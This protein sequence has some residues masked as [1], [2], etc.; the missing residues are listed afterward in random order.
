LAAPAI[1]TPD[2]RLRVFVSSTIEELAAEREA[3]REAIERLRLT[4]VLF[5]LGARSLPP[6]DVYRAYLDDSD[7]FVG[8]YGERYGWVGPGMERSGLEDE[9]RRSTSKPRLIYVKKSAA[10]RDVRLTALIEEIENDAAIS[11]KTFESAESL[12]ELL[13]DDLAVLLT[14]RFAG[15]R[16]GVRFRPTLPAPVD[17]FVGRVEELSRIDE[18]L[19]DDTR[20][21]TIAGPG[22]VGKS[23]LALE[24]ARRSEARFR[25]GAA[26]VPL[27]AVAEP[28]LVASTV[29]ATL[30]LRAD[31]AAD[32]ADALAEQLRDRD[33]LLV[34]DNFE[35]V[36][37][38]APTVG[39]LLARCP[40]LAVLAT[41]RSPLRIRGEHEL[42]IEPLGVP[43]PASEPAQVADADAVRLFADRARQLEPVFEL[44]S[45]NSD[46]IGELCRKLEGLPLALELAAARIRL[47]PPQAMLERVEAGLDVLAEGARDVPERQ[48]SLRATIEWSF[49]L[50]DERERAA[51]MEASVFRGGWDLGAAESVL[52][53]D[54]VERLD[55]LLEHSLIKRLPREQARFGMLESIRALAAERL[56]ATGRAANV[57]RGHAAFYLA[58]VA[59]LTPALYGLGQTAALQAIEQEHDNL[60]AAIEWCL[61][62]DEPNAVAEVA[63]GLMHFWWLRGN[64]DEGL[65]LMDHVLTASALTPANR[66]R[67]LLVRGFLGFWRAPDTGN[68]T[69][70]T[71]AAAIF[72]SEG[73]RANAALARVPVGTLRA[74]R[75]DRDSLDDLR[76]ART[77]LLESGDAWGSLLATN[78]LCWALNVLEEDAPLSLYEDGVARAT[79]A[80]VEAELATALGNL[81]RRHLL[82]D[83]PEEAQGRLVEAL[84]I[85]ERLRSRT[86]TA[87]YVSAFAD[88]AARRGELELAVRLFAA[89]GGSVPVFAR[90]RERTLVQARELHGE[91]AVAELERAGRELG[92]EAAAREA[93][94]WAK[95]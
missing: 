8:I 66:A 19:E 88:L 79:T 44:T 28:A 73:D 48:R 40:E 21:I 9:F 64:L 76:A 90:D 5:D 74:A 91:A 6:A 95:R 36:L 24:A 82:R 93:L 17:G 43:S 39:E 63:P 41:S 1:R 62:D 23:R 4:P 54:A 56:D 46:A 77:V 75:G 68:A 47:L 38:A 2:Q 25:D 10:A 12:F 20:L 70:F 80:G 16:D 67:A 32:S 58:L 94:A 60:R 53:P 83:E 34:L 69:D 50:L 30:A 72:D 49:D 57:R 33:L 7:V 13:Q 71:E 61:A 15:G 59:R 45:E 31:A 35:Q 37:D 11:Y 55:A 18:L 87:Y 52:G 86:G 89:A 14:E 92:L 42:R 3:A 81:A 84:Q 27:D 51:L 29:L 22:G 78:G 26:F 65:R 85:V